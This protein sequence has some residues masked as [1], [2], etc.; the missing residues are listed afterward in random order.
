VA[1]GVDPAVKT[2]QAPDAA[3]IGDGIVIETG[4]KQLR[5]RNHPMLR[6][7]DPGD[8]NVGCGELLGTIAMN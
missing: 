5:D 2:M 8:Q 1:H 7:G 6:S 4:S 3:T